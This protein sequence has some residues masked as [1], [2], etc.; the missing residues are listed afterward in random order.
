M[1]TDN[2][3]L[4]EMT[5]QLRVYTKQAEQQFEQRTMS[6]GYEVDFFGSAKPFADKVQSLVDE[7][8]PLASEWAIRERPKYVYPIQIKDTSENLTIIAVQ[9]FQK[10]T[11]AK[12]F[13]AM[14]KSIDY[15]LESMEKQL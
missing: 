7:W 5:K 1:T 3:R 2:S 12:R 13:L 10:D 14:T 15:I 8:K 4:N 9:A 11:K 6:D